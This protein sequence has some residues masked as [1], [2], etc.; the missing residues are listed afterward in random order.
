L[1][2][3]TQRAREALT[4]RLR[5]IRRS[6]GAT[7]AQFAG[8]LGDGWGQPKVSKIETGKQLPTPAEIEAWAATA[9]APAGEL[10]A[11]LDRARIEYATFR[12][13]FVELAGADRVQDAIGAAELAATRI[14][15]YEPILVPG[16]LQTADYARELLHLP[17]GPARSGASEEEINRMI[18]SRLRRQAIL[19]EPGRDITLILGEGALR[20][21]VATP[22][23][24]HAQRE[25]IA[26]LGETLST[27][28]I[29]I[30]PFAAPAP[31][32]TLHGWLL[33]D[34]L[35]TI[36]TDA[37]NLEIADAQHVERYW[38]HTRLLLDAAAIG[39]NAAIVCRQIND[40]RA[41][42]SAQT[43]PHHRR[44]TSA[45]PG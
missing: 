39:H 32:A 30:L 41:D 14:A 5:Q 42:S 22:T 26:R 29:G 12:D 1:A 44:D 27:A 36:E 8:R 24:M 18:A 25:H 19:Y 3:P 11:L 31:I 15:H 4:E 16:I 20:T 43:G 40:E 28:T 23:T 45:R 33:T 35:A 21:R 38:Q 6:T 7:G 9:D 17:S 13:R 2:T 37:G 10:L 34:G